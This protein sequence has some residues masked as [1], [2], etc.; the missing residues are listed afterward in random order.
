MELLLSSALVKII[1]KNDVSEIRSFNCLK[2]ESFNFQ[3][4]VCDT[5]N[6]VYEIGTKSDLKISCYEVFP[7]KGN[8]DFNVKT[9]DY[10]IKTESDTYPELLIPV[11]KI[12]CGKNQNK[13][14]FFEIDCSEKAAGKHDVEVTVGDKSVS[15]SVNVLNENLTDSDLIVTHWFHSD[16]ICNY[17]N[18]KPFSA[19][20]YVH[21]KDFMRA[22]VK[23]GNNMLLVPVFTPP[24][25]TE[26]GGER[27]TTQLLKIKKVGNRYEFDFSDMKKYID[28]AKSF[29]IKYFELSHLFTQWGGE[30]CPKI[31]VEENGENIK[32]FGWNVKSDDEEYSEFLKQYFVAL[33]DFLV[34]ESIKDNT[35]MHLTD[36]PKMK[37]IEKYS[38]LSAFVKKYN[39]GIKTMDALSHFDFIEKTKLDL[40]A[41]A[42]DSKQIDLFENVRKLFYY[43]VRVDENYLSNRYFH[44]PLL[45]TAILGMQLYDKRADGFLHWGFNFY[46]TALSIATIDPY[47]DATAG[48]K[49][50]AGDPFIV[51]P[52]EKGVNYSIRYFA[53]LKAFED[54]RLLK[55]VENK[56]GRA[57]VKEVLTR[58]G[59]CG[60]HEYPPDVKKYEELKNQLYDLLK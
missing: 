20:W 33:N 12:E 59:V 8:Y 18:V 24:L 7:C 14:L 6:D 38:E 9:D 49:F 37:D 31:I 48:G 15:F 39:F 29:G 16:A 22:Y 17:F 35:F 28:E 42:T 13:T 23:M 27:L 46:N 3:I 52:A 47:K 54:Y 44:M 45:R 30:F 58:N 19:E 26:V 4:Y 2:N 32:R 60:L 50:V 53:L 55:T 10:Y 40:P 21:F 51:Y 1:D 36:E 41:V 57:V 43:C 5:E 25:D 34:K 11:N 56:A